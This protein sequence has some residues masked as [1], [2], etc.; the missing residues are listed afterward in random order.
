MSQAG[1]ASKREHFQLPETRAKDS[2][3]RAWITIGESKGRGEHVGK[4]RKV[5]VSSETVV[6][7]YRICASIQSSMPRNR[8]DCGLCND[9]AHNL[10]D[11][12][13]S[14]R[15]SGIADISPSSCYSDCFSR[16]QYPL[17]Y[18]RFP[19]VNPHPPVLVKLAH[20]RRR[21][22]RQYVI[23]VRPGPFMSAP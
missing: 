12:R 6:R 15:G 2:W 17:L 9:S 22:A 4:H 21:I 3:Q 16:Y 20:A 14:K 18:L 23:A 11:T 10:Q 13:I 8:S 19:G 5:T 7:T 1:Y